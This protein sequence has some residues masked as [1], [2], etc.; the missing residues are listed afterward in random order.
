MT[1]IDVPAHLFE[2]LLAR[3]YFGLN[4]APD[5]PP[6][7]LAV[8]PDDLVEEPRGEASGALGEVWLALWARG[9]TWQSDGFPPS[10]PPPSW[11]L[12]SG[13]AMP[14]ELG[15]SWV[16]PQREAL[17]EVARHETAGKTFW[18]VFGGV[19]TDW[20]LD[21]LPVIGRWSTRLGPRRWAVSR[22]VLE[23][24]AEL[25]NIVAAEEG[26]RVRYTSAPDGGADV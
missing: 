11:Q 25:A 16:T 13:S 23:D 15:W 22:A 12:E 14:A 10:Q 19:G 18:Q 9:V 5:I 26:G 1:S 17:T 20:S 3:Q 24:A 4:V 8:N 7:P 6:V 21:V 2:L